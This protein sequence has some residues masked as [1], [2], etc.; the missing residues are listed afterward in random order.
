M[1]WYGFLFLVFLAFGSK[2][3]NWSTLASVRLSAQIDDARPS[4]TLNWVLESDALNYV[5]T[6]RLAGSTVWGVSLATVAGTISKFTDTTVVRGQAYE[7]RV[8]KIGTSINGVGYLIGG[9]AV[10]AIAPKKSILLLVD[11]QIKNGI[12]AEIARLI[13]DLENESWHVIRQ[14]VPVS[15]TA[16]E[17]KNIIKGVRSSYAGLSTVFIIG[18][19]AVPYSG[20]AAW[21]GHTDHNGAWPSDTYYADLDGNWTDV[22]VNTTN[23][24]RNQN[25]NIPGDGKF[26]PSQLPSDADLEVG[27]VDFFDMPVFVKSEI[28]LLKNYL[29]KDHLFRTGKIKAG[30]KAVVADNFNFQ[31]EFFGSSGYKNFSSFFGPDSV[32]TADYRGSLL[33]SSFMWSY[34][35]GGGTYTSAGGISSSTSMATDSLRGIFTLLFGSYHGDWDSQNN[36]MRSALGSGTVLTCAWA[37][38]PGWQF[39]HMALGMNIGF[40]ARTSMNNNGAQYEV[41]NVGLRGTHMGLMGDPSLNMYP[42]AAP[43]NL[44][45]VEVKENIIVSWKPSADAKDGYSVFRKSKSELYYRLIASQVK[46]TIHID[47]CLKI[48]STYDYLVTSTQLIQNASGSFYMNSPGIR[49]S[50]MVQNDNVTKAKFNHSLDYE[51]LSAESVSKNSISL[52]WSLDGKA[53]SEVVFDERIDCQQNGK[54]KLRLIAIGA[55]NSDTA[56]TSFDYLCSTPRVIQSSISPAILC[57]GDSTVIS[58]DEI[59]GAAPF[60][61]QWS[62]GS[63]DQSISSKVSGKVS[64]IITSAKNTSSSLE[65]DLPSFPELKI[66]SILVKG[67]VPGFGRGKI[68]SVNSSGGVGPYLYEVKGNFDPE[69]LPAGEYELILTDANGCT[70]SK[71]FII[72]LNTSTISTGERKV[73]IYPNPVSEDLWINFDGLISGSIQILVYDLTGKVKHTFKFYESNPRFSRLKLNELAAGS[74]I[75]SIE[76]GN[77]HIKIPFI[78]TLR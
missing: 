39:H 20:N 43:E 8:K 12:Q 32:I 17:V 11:D 59:E 67:E 70:V 22:S 19:V 6:R 24:A 18:H 27:R 63:S 40:S 53:G 7:Y 75:L 25:K 50:I 46:D 51:F 74:Y 42:I 60:T 4:I 31:G 77:R 47:K 3:Q 54:T 9:I 72:T 14:D 28:Q 30:Q 62:Q 78:K 37:G 16:I 57:Y 56:E 65:F 48:D 29:D 13:N 10:P 21:D 61:Y 23:P 58:I 69:D 64:V 15:S 44:N 26:D 33:S 34:G 38:R 73:Q 71:K 68:L 2:A 76:D 49:K 52:L 35:A 55:C 66:D 45:I 5:I 36:F 1:K 41:S